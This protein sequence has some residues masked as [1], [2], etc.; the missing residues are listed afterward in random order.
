[1]AEAE[2]WY[3]SLKEH[4]VVREGEAKVE[5]RLG[6]YAT[7]EE[8]AQALKHVEERNETWETDPR[9]NDPEEEE[10]KDDEE[11]VRFDGSPIED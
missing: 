6:P 4:R 9:F 7:Q 11:R 8:A 1:M 3:W 2:Q 5:D 10:E